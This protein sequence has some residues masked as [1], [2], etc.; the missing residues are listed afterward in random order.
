VVSSSTTG[1]LGPGDFREITAN[2]DGKQ[3]FY[4]V[5]MDAEGTL[6]EIYRENGRDRP[7]D[8][9]ARAWIASIEAMPL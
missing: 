6:T 3:R 1:A 8:E 7:L 4:R 2:T 5:S 9:D